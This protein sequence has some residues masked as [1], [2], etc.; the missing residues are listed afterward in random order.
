MQ[1]FANM[2]PA[3]NARSLFG[4]CGSSAGKCT[5]QALLSCL[6]CCCAFFF[7]VFAPSVFAAEIPGVSLPHDEAKKHQL[8]AAASGQGSASNDQGAAS[9]S[10]TSGTTAPVAPTLDKIPAPQV[11]PVKDLPLAPAGV[12]SAPEKKEQ[13]G[14]GVGA[15]LDQMDAI[16]KRTQARPATD[17]TVPDADADTDDTKDDSS[18][19]KAKTKPESQ[20]DAPAP[21]QTARELEMQRRGIV[22]VELRP[23]KPAVL[24]VDAPA[25]V[26]SIDVHDGEDVTQGQVVATLDAQ[27][28]LKQLAEAK[29]SLAR[30]VDIVQQSQSASAGEQERAQTDL[31][32]YAD[33]V[34]ELEEYIL[35]SSL[36]A[37]FDGRVTQVNVRAG[38]HLKRGEI[39]L[40]LA[41]SDDMEIIATVPSSWVSRLTSGHLIW[42]YVEEIGKSYEAEFIR[43]GGR[44]SSSTKTIRA[45]A[46]FKQN[47]PELLPGMS[48]RADFFPR[49]KGQSK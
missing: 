23:A 45:Y 36:T 35:G 3:R 4:L 1:C 24:S 16:R 38:Q 2:L 44:V 17:K 7:A 5:N 15:V 25:M 42:V 13:G 34:R 20:D 26:A 27:K 49:V 40:E 29:E 21:A 41:K 46:A 9:R 14:L 19:A 18:S 30:S 6:V 48:G 32:R 47:H 8:Y 39:V 33:R 10:G 22:R 11:T 12:V 31:A 37:P 28:L 43:F